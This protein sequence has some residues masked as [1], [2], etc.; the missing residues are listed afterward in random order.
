M[1][2]AKVAADGVVT[3]AKAVASVPSNIVNTATGLFSDDLS[4]QVETLH[5]QSDF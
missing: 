1:S 2:G 3:G 4:I 5:Y